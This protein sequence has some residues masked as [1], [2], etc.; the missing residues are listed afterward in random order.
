MIKLFNLIGLCI[1]LII[2]LKNHAYPKSCEILYGTK[3]LSNKQR[4]HSFAIKGSSN[5][6]QIGWEYHQGKVRKEDSPIY[7]CC[8]N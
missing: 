8:T 2:P 1:F 4:D 7:A 3:A 6:Y 5:C